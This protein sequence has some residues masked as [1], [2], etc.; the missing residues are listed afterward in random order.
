MQIYYFTRSGRSQKIAGEL[1]ARYGVQAEQIKDGKDWQ[2]IGGYIKACYVAIKSQ[3]LPGV[4]KIPGEDSPIALV[5]PI[6]AGTFPPVVR[7][8]IS[9]VGRERI[10]CIPTS[11]GSKLKDRGG[12]S[13]VIDLV[14][15]NIAA[16]A[17][18]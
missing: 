8:F 12:F 1:A 10:I 6:W 18:L 15:A 14:G 4:Y 17:E 2:G 7:Q 13:K 11:G 16:P 3:S 5:F 9:A